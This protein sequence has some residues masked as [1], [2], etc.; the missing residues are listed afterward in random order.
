MAATA[1]DATATRRSLG[2]DSIGFGISSGRSRKRSAYRR[3]AVTPFLAGES[4]LAGS[5][6]ERRPLGRSLTQGILAFRMLCRYTG[7]QRSGS[8][9]GA[10][11]GL[12]AHWHQWLPCGRGSADGGA[13]DLRPFGGECRTPACAVYAVNRGCNHPVG[14]GSGICAL[15]RHTGTQSRQVAVSAAR[16][17]G[18]AP[19]RLNG[20]DRRRSSGGPPVPAVPAGEGRPDSADDSGC[21]VHERGSHRDALVP[22]Y[23]DRH[24]ISLRQPAP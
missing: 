19:F 12:R 2:S 9:P 11:E 20:E 4:I 13:G 10:A 17:A 8:L 18:A 16:D 22:R 3:G 1:T 21:D 24:R 6:R 15:P 14:L 7:A 5:C 23:K